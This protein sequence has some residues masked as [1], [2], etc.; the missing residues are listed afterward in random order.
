MAIE[1]LFGRTNPNLGINVPSGDDR[2]WQNEPTE[3]SPLAIT[4]KGPT[5]IL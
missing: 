2:I 4:S 1:R 3:L 5:C